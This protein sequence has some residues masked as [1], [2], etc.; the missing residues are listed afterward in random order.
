M[1]RPASARAAASPLQSLWG[2]AQDALDRANGVWPHPQANRQLSLDCD[3]QVYRIAY[4][5]EAARRRTIGISVSAQGLRVRAPHW[6]AQRHID[7]ALQ[8]RAPWIISKLQQQYA[9]AQEGAHAPLRWHDG[10]C[11]AYR[12]GQVR[13]VLGLAGRRAVLQPVAMAAPSGQDGAQ[14]GNGQDAAT[15]QGD[16][17]CH[18]LHLPLPPRSSAAQI[19][20]SVERW[21]RQQAL[22]LMQERLAIYAPRMGVTPSGLG[23]TSAQTRW[24]SASSNGRIRLHWRLAQM[25]LPLF[26]YVLVHELAH[27]HEMNHGPRFWQWVAEVM[28]DYAEQRARLK[29]VR[30]PPWGGAEGA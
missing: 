12:G 28:P 1:T 2:D 6:L 15:G 17:A 14:Q 10:A 18:V 3:G 21:L 4:R 22:A 11:F 25:D 13:V 7:T 9:A 16:V 5:L 8:E 24:G 30:L 20:A 27:L 29:Q 19:A 26:D 23:L